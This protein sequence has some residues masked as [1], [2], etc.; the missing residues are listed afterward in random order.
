[1]R[2]E[3]FQAVVESDYKLLGKAPASESV[4]FKAVEE[5]V[6]GHYQ[7]ILNLYDYWTHH[8]A[9]RDGEPLL[10]DI[11]VRRPGFVRP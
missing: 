5:R 7:I 8:A 1:M 2:L 11:Q 4:R 3:S 6:R 9:I 10:M